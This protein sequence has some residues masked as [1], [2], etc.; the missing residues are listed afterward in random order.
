LDIKDTTD[1]AGDIVIP[2]HPL[3]IY[4]LDRFLSVPPFP[5]YNKKLFS[6]WMKT[7]IER[8]SS[9]K[10]TAHCYTATQGCRQHALITLSCAHHKPPDERT[11]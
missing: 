4:D 5:K 6:K 10:L 2:D 3:D 9:L 11:C 8:P 1:K 7:N